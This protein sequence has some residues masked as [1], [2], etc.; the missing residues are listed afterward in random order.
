MQLIYDEYLLNT[1]KPVSRSSFYM[2]Y[3]KSLNKVALSL[4]L[5][6]KGGEKVFVDYS[7]DSFVIHNSNTGDILKTQLFVCCFGASRYC[8]AEATLS[9]KQ[10]DFT[11][12]H[13]RAF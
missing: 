9:Q 7:G 8:Y 2:Y 5:I 11:M 13:V 6:H 3:R 10:E 1:S 12:S 4:K